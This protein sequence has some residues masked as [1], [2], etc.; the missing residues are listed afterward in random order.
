MLNSYKIS[1][2]QLIPI[3]LFL[4]MAFHDSAAMAQKSPPEQSKFNVFAVVSEDIEKHFVKAAETLQQ[5]ENLESFPLKGYQ[6]HCTLYMT[7]F[8]A[9]IENEITQKIAELASNTSE[10]EIQTTGLE[11]TAGD[12]FFMNL[13]RNRNLQTLSDRVVEILSPLRAQS[14][15]IPE[16]AKQ[17]PTK[18]EYITKYGSPNVYSEFNP[19]LTMLA[20]S[21]GVKLKN[22]IEKHKTSDFA[23]KIAGKIVAIGIGIGDRDGQINTPLHIFKLKSVK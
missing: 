10:F 5:E 21:D 17:F 7:Q 4:F 9:D 11:I 1:L 20:K 12:W 23:Q 18:L 6:V 14:D 22:F 3:I 8:P 15:Y 13:D 19:H 2:G 16:W